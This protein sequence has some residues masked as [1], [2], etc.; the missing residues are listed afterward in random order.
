MF[1][2]CRH[3]E[4][5]CALA[6]LETCL[7]F[8]IL[9]LLSWLH[10]TKIWSQVYPRIGIKYLLQHGTSMMSHDCHNQVEAEHEG[11]PLLARGSLLVPGV[12]KFLCILGSA[13]TLP[14]AGRCAVRLWLLVQRDWWSP[15]LILKNSNNSV[16]IAFL[17]KSRKKKIFL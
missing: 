14:F 15:E 3:L 2:R 16:I 12:V 4:I 17:G 6:I 1:C 5:I 7:M 13:H 11:E 10:L 9:P 8:F